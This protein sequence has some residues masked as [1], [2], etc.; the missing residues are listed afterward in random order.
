MSKFKKL[1]VWQQAIDLAAEIYE[2]TGKGRFAKDFGLRNQI[3]RAVV[4]IA[5]N[6]AEGDERDSDKQSA[7][8]FKIAKA[9]NAEAITQL[10]I[11][12]RI[13]YIDE[14][15][16]LKLE[17]LAMKIGAGLYGLIRARGGYK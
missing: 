16:L 1:W 4:S 12:Q 14:N 17:T 2:L 9:S 7:H 13:G 6:I 11:A 8:F 5:S 15:V 3:Q 10:N